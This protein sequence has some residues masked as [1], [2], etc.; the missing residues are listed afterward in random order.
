MS[1]TMKRNSIFI[2]VLA[3]LLLGTGGASWAQNTS[4]EVTAANGAKQT[5]DGVVAE[6]AKVTRDG[7][8]VVVDM[9]L[10]LSGMKVKSS[11]AVLLTPWLVNGEDS[12]ALPSIGIYG[13]QR[14]Y[15][16]Q[17]R[18]GERMISGSDETSFR[19]GDD[20]DAVP[21]SAVVTYRKWMND[22][23]LV[24][25]RSEYACCGNSVPGQ[26][27]ELV[28]RA[29]WVP[30]VPELIYVCPESES[31]KT[32]SLSGRAYIDFPVDR[33]EIHPDYHNN[34]AELGKIRAT[35][36]S[37]RNDKD[38]TVT[39]VWL[40]GYASPEGTYVHNTM[41]A[42]E[43]TAT[44][45]EYVLKLYDFDPS[46]VTF[47]HEPENWDGLIAWLRA[48]SLP[49]AAE[50]LKIAEDKEADPDVREFRIRKYFPEDYKTMK[51]EIYPRLRCTEY[52]ID[53]SI[54]GYADPKE[55]LRV[56]KTNPGKL[57]LNEFFIAAKSLEAGSPEFNEVFDIA[58]VM[59]PDDAVAN[60]NAANAAMG[61][62]DLKTAEARLSKAGDSAEA[63]YS[64]G[65]FAV[66][67][68]DYTNAVDFFRKAAEKGL[69]VAAEQAEVFNE[70]ACSLEAE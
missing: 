9:N 7:S 43:R 31:I 33:T 19:A 66:M 3:T 63:E 59:Y 69:E 42:R 15:Y 14:Y 39:S 34:L 35:I 47:D 67:N 54:R 51:A 27:A 20:M 21:Y 57:S 70:Y 38:I 29:L 68:K 11:K 32:R 22:C 41:L 25:S 50:I 12:L 65:V 4:W 58:A 26:R 18:D 5:V 30:D 52:K 49:D 13:R 62:G 55:I 64:R 53:Y 10:D 36:D 40:K 2:N 48:S 23:R 8:K 44:I 28:S 6:K 61:R 46:V 45:R 24:L 17:R 37:V 60:L 16:Y 1:E 56:M